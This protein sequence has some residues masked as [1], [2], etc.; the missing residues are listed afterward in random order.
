MRCRFSCRLLLACAF[1]ALAGCSTRETKQALAKA[2]DLASQQHYDE[3]N[4]VLIDALKARENKIRGD[5]E[6]P[7]TD[8]AAINALTRKVQADSEILKMER[9][10]IPL[11]LHLQ[12]SDLASAVY[13][14]I[15]AGH[16]GDQVLVDLLKDKDPKI[17]TRVVRTLGLNANA[18][19]IDPLIT[20][21]KDPD[22]D[23]R[24]EAVSSLGM[25]QDP[26]T[27]PTLIHALNDTYSFVRSQAADA[28]EHEKDASAI[29]PLLDTVSDPDE[30]V[31]GAAEN[32]L[33]NLCQLPG[34]PVTTFAAHLDD[35]NAKVAMISTICLAVMKDP[36]AT[37]ILIKMAASPDVA[38]RLHAVKGLGETGD[39]SVIPTL[40]QTLKDPEVNV[41][42]WSIIGLDNLKDTGSIPALQAMAKDP[43]ETA[44]IHEFA[45]LAVQHLTSQTVSSTPGDK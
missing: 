7:L 40:R 38:T 25:I 27:V 13:A 14:D 24:S 26:R 35:S 41:R 42:G 5:T 43:N 34:V 17:R 39:P 12:R 9:A 16:P 31:A 45:A 29:N 23:V 33:A 10:Q 3:A 20:A 22:E 28:L 36:R 30:D 2:D 32:A 18:D 15:I 6:I 19:A 1:L 11:Y 4:A 8:T 21:T 37:P 44:H